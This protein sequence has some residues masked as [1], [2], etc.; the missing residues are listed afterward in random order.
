M[1]YS[2]KIIDIIKYDINNQKKKI[3]YPSL[4][5]DVLSYKWLDV[6]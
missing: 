4:S 3:E 1:I 6:P 5:G 2:N